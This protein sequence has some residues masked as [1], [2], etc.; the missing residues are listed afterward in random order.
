MPKLLR[1]EECG[2]S[3]LTVFLSAVSRR[4]APSRF[5]IPVEVSYFMAVIKCF[6]LLGDDPCLQV[7]GA[8]LL[9]PEIEEI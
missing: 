9:E 1:M 3:G 5:Q 6:A 2:G 8:T 7:G 4:I